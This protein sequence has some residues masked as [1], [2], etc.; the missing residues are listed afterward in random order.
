MGVFNHYYNWLQNFQIQTRYF[1]N[2][3]LQNILCIVLP[4]H[5]KLL[6]YTKK[7]KSAISWNLISY[8]TGPNVDFISYS[9]RL[10]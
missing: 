1:K 6:L 7:L 4:L 10:V 5:F 3:L 8:I 9:R 2:L